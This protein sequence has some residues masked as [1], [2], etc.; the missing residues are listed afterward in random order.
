MEEH[1]SSETYKQL[2]A[3]K[4]WGWFKIFAMRRLLRIEKGAISSPKNTMRKL[5]VDLIKTIF[6]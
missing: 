6:F 5:E 4:M 3:H 2:A 1:E